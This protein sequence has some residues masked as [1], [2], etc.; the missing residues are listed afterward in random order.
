LGHKNL[1]GSEDIYV[2]GAYGVKVYPSSEQSADNGYVLTNE[3]FTKLPTFSS[4]NHK[5]GLFYDMGNV[6][7]EVNQ[8][9]TF[10]RRTL[11]DVGVGYYLNYKDMFAK[12]QMAWTLNSKPITSEQ[13]SH[14]NSK[15][16]FQAGWVF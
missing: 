6:Y 8:D 12:V 16:L 7:Q 1:D 13:T 4:Y 11:Q 2:G 5:I 3:L 14:Q 10:E 9:V 15:L